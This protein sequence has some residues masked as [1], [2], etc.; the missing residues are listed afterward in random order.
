MKTVLIFF[1]ISIILWHF[2]HFK[3]GLG[4]DWGPPSLLRTIGLLLDSEVADLIK[5]VVIT[6]PDGAY[7]NHIIPSYCHLPV[8]CRILVDQCDSLG[9][10][11]PQI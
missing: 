7:P 4:L 2:P 9:I 11:K 5:K 3:S 6:R 1:Y 8:S 10:C